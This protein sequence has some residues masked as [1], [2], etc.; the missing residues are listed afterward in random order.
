MIT[1]KWS[2]EQVFI[3]GALLD[4]A[5]SLKVMNHSAEFNWGYGGSGPAQLA[6]ALLL[7]FLPDNEALIM[8][9]SF[10]WQVIATLPQA[11][12]ELDEQT[13]K[14]WIAVHVRRRHMKG[15]MKVKTFLGVQRVHQ[16]RKAL[17][18]VL[19]SES[20]FVI[21]VNKDKEQT[22]DMFKNVTDEYV[23]SVVQNRIKALGESKEKK[24]VTQLK[25]LI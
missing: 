14:N 3:D 20:G 6:L 25:N 12:F 5:R 10:K 9:Q 17:A 22:C 18:E 1:G 4:V 13:I 23:L 15:S 8:H 24:D 11:D 19:N 2:T 16:L 7:R 21:I